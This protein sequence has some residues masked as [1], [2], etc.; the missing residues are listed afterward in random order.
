MKPVIRRYEL[1]EEE[2]EWLKSVFRGDSP[3]IGQTPERFTENA[4]W[5]LLDRTKRSGMA[6]SAREIRTV[7]D[8]VQAVQR[9]GKQRTD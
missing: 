2:W 5:N 7:A 8:S 6:G 4:E 3:D 1:T 9:V